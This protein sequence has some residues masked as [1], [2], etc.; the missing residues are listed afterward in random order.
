[1]RIINTIIII[2]LLSTLVFGCGKIKQVMPDKLIPKKFKSKDKTE[3]T[4]KAKETIPSADDLLDQYIAKARKLEV[5]GELVKA[6]EQYRL[7][8]T[9]DKQNQYAIER[10]N[11]LQITCKEYAEKHYSEGLAYIKKAN[12]AKHKRNF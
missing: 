8:L 9:V 4:A 6:I 3:E 11:E 12:S 2:V 7:A 5:K 1:M 10:I